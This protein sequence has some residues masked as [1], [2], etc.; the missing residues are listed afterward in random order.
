MAAYWCCHLLEGVIIL[1]PSPWSRGI[2]GAK[3]CFS[4][5]G[6]A[7]AGTSF[8]YHSLPIGYKLHVWRSLLVVYACRVPHTPCSSWVKLAL[9]LDVVVIQ[10]VS[11]SGIHPSSSIFSSLL[12]PSNQILGSVYYYRVHH[13]FKDSSKW[14]ALD[15]GRWIEDLLLDVTISFKGGCCVRCVLSCISFTAFSPHT[16]GW[17]LI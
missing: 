7:C 16:V 2:S 3:P 9:A 17:F 1:F 11:I 6:L 10:W 13:P 12:V 5:I 14:R 8:L 4:S 15:G